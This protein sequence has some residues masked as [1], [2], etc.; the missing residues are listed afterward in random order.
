MESQRKK[1]RKTRESEKNYVFGDDDYEL[2]QDDVGFQR[3][4]SDGRIREIDIPERMQI[5]EES[6]GPP[7]TDER[8]IDDESKWILNQLGT[9][10]VPLFSKERHGLALDKGD[11]VRFLEFTHVQKLD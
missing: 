6:T 3:R 8:S 4:K 1:K 2:L 5:S 9:G 7:P 10:M 11:V